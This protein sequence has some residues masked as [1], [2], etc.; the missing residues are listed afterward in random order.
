MPFFREHEHQPS[1]CQLSKETVAAVVVSV[2]VLLVLIKPVSAY[3]FEFDYFETDKLV[4]EVGETIHMV[5]KLTADFSDQGWCYVSFAVTTGQGPVF[6]NSYFIPPSNEARFFNSS[7]TVLPQDTSPGVAGIQAYVMFST[8][9]YDSYSQGDGDT[10]QVNITRGGLKIVSLSSLSLE[11]GTNSTLTFKI[12]SIHNDTIAYANS[13]ASISLLN[14]SLT[15]LLEDNITT[16]SDGLIHFSLNSSTTPPGEYSLM[17]SSNGTEDF[18][19]ISQSFPLTITQPSSNLTVISSSSSVHCQTHDGSQTESVDILL[20][21]KNRDGQPISDST[22]QWETM[23][24]AGTMINLGSGL[25]NV[26]IPFETGPGNY[27][28]NLT[29]T[30]PFY[31]TETETIEIEATPYSL[32][33]LWANSTWDALRG[34]NVS[35][36]FSVNS[37]LLL[38]QSIS[39][40]IGDLRGQLVTYSSIEVNAYS[41]IDLV[42]SHNAS[43]G[44]HTV[45]MDIEEHSYQ[46]NE[47]AEFELLV[48]GIMD[49]SCEPGMAYYAEGMYIVLNVTDETNQSVNMIDLRVWIDNLTNPIAFIEDANVT[50]P[51]Q[52]SLPLSILPGPHQVTL[53]VSSPWCGTTN[54]STSVVVW[55][56]TII[57]VRIGENHQAPQGSEAGQSSQTTQSYSVIL[58]TIS[59]GSIIRPPPILANDT[60]FTESPTALETSRNSWPRLSSGTNN[61]PTDFENCATSPSGNGQSVLN[62]RDLTLKSEMFVMT[63]STDLEVHP[64]ET[65]PQSALRGPD[66]TTSVKSSRSA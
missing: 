23:F 2:V 5:A 49:V 52:I 36:G 11:F 26:S 63:S 66:T 10:I 41:Q 13:P 48:T 61:E 60:T 29:A 24:S 14:S 28:V 51:V 21:Q 55:M 9:I 50:I 38:N 40:R 56:R 44:P 34:T 16:T 54:I 37:T 1:V 12:A 39:V 18:T 35:I 15:E 46:F 7:Y 57:T 33:L 42:V 25:Y 17:I 20:E 22:I 31:R 8:E 4:Y 58:L 32:S 27:H 65:I 3:Y 47:P 6:G 43:L 64:Y 59:S 30:N 62:L 45:T 19:P 53:Q